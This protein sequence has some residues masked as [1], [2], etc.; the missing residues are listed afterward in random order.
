MTFHLKLQDEVKLTFLY[1]VVLLYFIVKVFVFI[2]NLVA[3]QEDPF[4]SGD[5]F[6]SISNF[7]IYT[8]KQAYQLIHTY[9]IE[10]G[11]IIFIEPSLLWA[12]REFQLRNRNF[13]ILITHDNDLS[14]PGNFRHYLDDPYLIRWFGQNTDYRHPKLEGLPIGIANAHWVHG[15]QERLLRIGKEKKSTA[16]IFKG[17]FVGF[18]ADT[19]IRRKPLKDYFCSGYHNWT[20]CVKTRT[21]VE[22]YLR[23]IGTMQFVLS[24]RGNGL[25]CHRTWESIAMGA[26]PV[27]ETSTLDDMLMTERVLIV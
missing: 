24:P 5:F 23:K 7:V 13:Y 12:V 16:E 18:M 25:D 10:N 26:I 20:Y 4:V 8:E 3:V 11:S 15:N 9:K 27:V 17:L 19:D 14:V 2:P 21:S 1:T 22:D 6:R